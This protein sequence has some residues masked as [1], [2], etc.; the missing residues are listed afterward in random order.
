MS[1]AIRDV[2]AVRSSEGIYIWPQCTTK[3]NCRPGSCHNEILCN[4]FHFYCENTLK[5]N[6]WISEKKIEGIKEEIFK[7][8]LAFFLNLYLSA[9]VSLSCPVSNIPALQHSNS[10]QRMQL[11][12]WSPSWDLKSAFSETGICASFL[13]Q[14]SITKPPKKHFLFL[15]KTLSVNEKT[16]TALTL[17]TV[18]HC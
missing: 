2:I 10:H 13:H 15:A 18:T 9:L 8:A 11:R 17:P 6:L 14:S 3:L 7:F 12:Y 16:T 1:K 5:Y 4:L